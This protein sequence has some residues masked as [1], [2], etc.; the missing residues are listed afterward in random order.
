[1][2]G[3]L[4]CDHDARRGSGERHGEIFPKTGAIAVPVLQGERVACCLNISFIASVL[5]PREAAAR[6]LEPIRAA[7]RQI[8][9]ALSVA[10]L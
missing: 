8:E 9:R 10:S 1:V 6:Y 5:T 7:P 4:P 3:L 2:G